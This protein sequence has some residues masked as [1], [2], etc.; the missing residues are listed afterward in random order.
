MVPRYEE[1]IRDVLT[2]LHANIRELRDRKGFADAEE[3]PHIEARKAAYEEA[4]SII[5]DSAG[6]F[7]I[8]KDVVD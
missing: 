1:F 4:V 3:L 6:E 7:G 8:P 5:R 2:T